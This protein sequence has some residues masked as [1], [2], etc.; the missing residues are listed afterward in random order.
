MGVVY[1]Y[2]L[3]WKCGHEIFLNYFPP[4]DHACGAFITQLMLE[5]SCSNIIFIFEN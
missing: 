1:N 4:V 3:V 2:V 5:N